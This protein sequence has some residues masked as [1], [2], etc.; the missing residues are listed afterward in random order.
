MG[1]PEPPEP[2]LRA[3][4]DRLEITDLL[5][6][7]ATALDGGD[8]DGARS[9]FAAGA[10]LDYTAFD[11]PRGEPAEVMAWVADA[12]SGFDM[13]QHLL[14]NVQVVLD[15]DEATASCYVFNPMGQRG[16]DGS[17]SLFYVGGTYHDRLRRTPDGWRITERVA[18]AA[19]FDT[20]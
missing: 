4:A 7:Y 18:R 17:L 11:G 15:G 6:R 16:A 2:S 10:V 19:F 5:T 13:S 1:A 20:R 3:L 12:L 14:G 9:V 8:W